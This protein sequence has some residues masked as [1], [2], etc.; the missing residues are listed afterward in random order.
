MFF[1]VFYRIQIQLKHK[2]NFELRRN[3]M[4]A[5]MNVYYQYW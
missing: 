3:H 5:S 1:S 2:N 4:Q